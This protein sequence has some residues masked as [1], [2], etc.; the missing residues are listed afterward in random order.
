MPEPTEDTRY[1]SLSDF[2]DMR[3]GNA[4]PDDVE[5]AETDESPTPAIAEPEA[6]ASEPSEPVGEAPTPTKEDVSEAARVLSHQKHETRRE[7]RIR[8]INEEIASFT[9]K[10][11]TAK[12]EADA[13]EGRLATLRAQRTQLEATPKPAPVQGPAPAPVAPVSTRPVPPNQADVG[14]AAIPDWDAFQALNTKFVNDSA[15]W[16]ATEAVRIAKETIAAEQARVQGET[17]TSAWLDRVQAAKAKHADFEAVVFHNP[18]LVIGQELAQTIAE[19]PDPVSTD[20]AYYLGTH[21]EEAL[22]ISRLKPL[23]QAAEY[24]RLKS[25]V[26]VPVVSSP[27]TTSPTP[28]AKPVSKT[29]APVPLVG[30]ASV[31][32]QVPTERLTLQQF[33]ARRDAEEARNGRL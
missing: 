24:G 33:A 25:V 16:A 20:V 26:P 6:V 7:K 9:A 32:T 2:M 28:S 3:D 30:V 14:T 5:V 10:K 13:E 1:K 31:S 12:A 27:K 17:A 21:P 22:R 4:A 29:P 18:S 15:D 23:A 11:S 19:D 8:E